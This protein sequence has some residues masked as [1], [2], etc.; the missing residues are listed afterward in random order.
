MNG[1]DRGILRPHQATISI[2]QKLLDL[3][4][5]C[6]GMSIV[7]AVDRAQCNYSAVIATLF[8]L[9]I[10]YLLSDF[11]QLY[12]SWRG[13]RIRE[14]LQKVGGVW[15]I[16]FAGVVVADYLSP[17]ITVLSGTGQIHW[18][19]LVLTGTRRLVRLPRAFALRPACASPS[20]L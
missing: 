17:E 3:S 11:G 15:A 4:V 8:A 1:M 6:L 5:I 2:L 19:S 7:I 18:F 10:F 14:E 20:R 9:V 12:V 13:E 16:S